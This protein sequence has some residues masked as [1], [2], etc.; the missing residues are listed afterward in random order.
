VLD[1]PLT[2]L[3][4]V[5]VSTGLLLG[6]G[7][8]MVLSASMVDSYVDL[9]TTYGVFA[10]QLTW[11]GVGIPAFWLGLRLSPRVHR[12]L[13][14]PALL[15]ALVLLTAVLVP[16]IG[17]GVN[18]ARRWIDLGP[19]QLQPSEPAKL[20]L[21]LWGADLLVRKRKLLQSAR[22]LMMPLLPVTAL[23]AG[24]IMLE[25]D[26]GSTLCLALV[27]FGLLW[28]VGAPPRVF[29]LLTAAAIA[30]VLVLIRVED[31]R[32]DRITAFLDPVSHRS[33]TGYQ[34][35][36]GLYSLSTGG[37]FGVG[38]GQSKMKWGL[39]PNA[40]TDYIFAIVGEE[41][42]LVGCLVVILLFATLT[43]AGI[44]IARRSADPFARLVAAAVTTWFAGQAAINMGYVTGLLPITGIPL[45]LISFGGTSLVVTLF[46]LGML[47]SF[48]RHE[49]A[50]V[51]HLARRRGWPSRLLGLPSPR[52]YA[53]RP[54]GRKRPTGSR[55]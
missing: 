22:H 7:L 14:Y 10:R 41:L 54:Q 48:A 5:L 45:P 44:R 19:L 33:D 32:L 47:A 39:L 50:A 27:M 18:G 51:T 31:Y 15:A 38:L 30:A 46:A 55:R 17:H 26:L 29:A 21:A 43:Y 28:T 11:V 2:S 3:H 4:L 9:G 13:A 49:P 53:E 34:A 42:G 40:H 35:V 1:R 8:V 24:L 36:Q 20:A 6:I 23:L 12:M 16:G 25:P 52:R 37:W